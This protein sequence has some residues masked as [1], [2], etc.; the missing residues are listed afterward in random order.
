MNRT[1]KKSLCVL[2]TLIMAFALVVPSFAAL[3]MNNYPTIRINGR[4]SLVFDKD[5]KQIYTNPD[6]SFNEVDYAKSLVPIMVKEISKT[7]ITQDWEGYS[8]T[9]CDKITPLFDMIQLD[10]NADAKD[11]TNG[12]EWKVGT[13]LAPS[14]DYTFQWDWRVDPLESAALLKE[15]IRE[16]KR[17]N[18]CDKV[19]ID[20]RCLGSVIATA[21]LYLAGDEAKDSIANLVLYVPT[22]VGSQT[23]GALFANQINFDD[24]AIDEFITYYMNGPDRFFNNTEYGDDLEV[25]IGTF[26]S[27]L[28]Q[29]KVLGYGMEA[30]T[31]IYNQIKDYMVPRLATNVF[32]F[33]T[34]WA[35]IDDR[36]YESAKEQLFKEN[37]DG[38]YTV[39]KNEY[40]GYIE[41]IDNYHY[42][43]LVNYEKILTDAKESGINISVI[44][45]YGNNLLPVEKDCRVQGD[46]RIETKGLSFGA[47]CSNI[48]ETLSDEY[49]ASHD[50]KYISADKKIDASTCLF[51]DS[52]WFV[53]D[54][55]HGTFP[56]CIERFK[57]VLIRS[58]EQ[59]TIENMKEYGYT[60]F[61]VYSEENDTLSEI[62]G[63]AES[64][65]L[66][67]HDFISTIF[68]FL[69]ALI[70]LLTK[71][72]AT[73]KA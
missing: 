19:N 67:N 48:T 22:V 12:G 73:K 32:F 37:S 33:P 57:S 9:I 44:A 42:N 54:C 72:M 36:Y 69:T 60:Q 14:S 5:G 38:Y 29:L 8:R 27:F 53:R 35:M 59:P 63:L 25:F 45:K 31:Y 52:T 68:R 20:S 71:I 50:S 21:Y 40:A 10:E 56:D 7:M 64:D 51:L 4:S 6:P 39:D 34:Y 49:I 66:Y 62:T 28:Y 58:K 3:E 70:K 43:V 23:V 17:V 41:K 18:N 13:P 61:M 55:A 47:T 65:K 1:F 26:C 2:L 24:K 11:G 30:I 16:V 46:G 15:Y